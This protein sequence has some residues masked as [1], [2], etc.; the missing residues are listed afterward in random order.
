MPSVESASLASLLKVF[1]GNRLFDRSSAEL[2]SAMS[3]DPASHSM[4][5]VLSPVIELAG[6]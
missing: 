4:L 3:S 1:R 5:T 2:E 6:S